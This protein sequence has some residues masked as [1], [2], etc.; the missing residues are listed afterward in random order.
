M[1][2]A[3]LMPG[4]EEKPKAGEGYF[5][6]TNDQYHEGPEDH[7]TQTVQFTSEETPVSK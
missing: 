3:L 1:H 7:L 6:P 5:M 2:N 4:H